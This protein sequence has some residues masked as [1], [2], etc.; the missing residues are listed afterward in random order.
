MRFLL[1]LSQLTC[2]DGV[3]MQAGVL[4]IELFQCISYREACS[5]NL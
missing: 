3:Y 4:N 2:W 1:L 5:N